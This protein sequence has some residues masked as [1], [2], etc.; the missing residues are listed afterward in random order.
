MDV[1]T[2]GGGDARSTSVSSTL[3]WTFTDDEM[4]REIL[5]IVARD[6][7]GCSSTDPVVN[8]YNSAHYGLGCLDDAPDIIEC[9]FDEAFFNLAFRQLFKLLKKNR[10]EVLKRLIDESKAKSSN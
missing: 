1:T 4:M 6:C 5:N 7:W 3:Q 10:S 8:N 9:N 2:S